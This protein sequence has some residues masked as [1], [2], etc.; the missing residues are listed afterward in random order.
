MFFE[1]VASANKIEKM[2]KEETRESFKRL[3]NEK[4]PKLS[5]SG[6]KIKQADHFKNFLQ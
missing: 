5:I 1:G 4:E 2:C 3:C 6:V